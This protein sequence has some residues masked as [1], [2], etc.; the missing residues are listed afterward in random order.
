MNLGMRSN[1]E[2]VIHS[3]AKGNTFG[4]KCVLLLVRTAEGKFILSS[5]NVEDQDI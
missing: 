5:E 4:L 1:Q 2:I 3:L